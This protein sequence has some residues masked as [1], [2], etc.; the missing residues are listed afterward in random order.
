MNRHW[1]DLCLLAVFG[2][3]LA[4]TACGQMGPLTLPEDPPASEDDESD[5]E[6]ER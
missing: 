1:H 4:V 5:D 2:L 3:L 6:D